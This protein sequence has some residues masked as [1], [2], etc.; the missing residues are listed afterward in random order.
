MQSRHSRRELFLF[1]L[2]RELFP[3]DEDRGARGTPQPGADPV[4]FMILTA[5]LFLL[6]G[7]IFGVLSSR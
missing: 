1:E 4:L 6:Y 5:V 2:I 3:G 7:L